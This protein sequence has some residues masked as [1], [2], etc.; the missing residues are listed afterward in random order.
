MTT[1]FTVEGKGVSGQSTEFANVVLRAGICTGGVAGSVYE[2]DPGQDSQPTLGHGPLAVAD[3]RAAALAPN[4]QRYA[5]K[6]AA[7]TAGE[8][9]T[10]TK[11]GSG[12]TLAVAGSAIDDITSPWIATDVK[13]KI[14]LG[15][16]L[17]TARVAVALDGAS[18]AYEFDLPAEAPATFIGT[19]DV[20]A[21]TLADL[22]TLTVILGAV[23]VTLTTPSSVANLVSQIHA[24]SGYA[25][26]LVQ[27]KYL[28]LR[29]DAAGAGEELT[30]GPGTANAL[31][32]FPDPV[33]ESAAEAAEITGTVDLTDSGLYGAM[34][35]LDGLTLIITSNLGASTVTFV[36]P[37]NAA[38][39]V[40]QITSAVAGKYVAAVVGDHLRLRST[41]VSATGT[42]LI[43]AGTSNSVLGFTGAAT[44]TGA[45]VVY[46][47]TATGSASAIT[48]PGTGQVITC[49]TG[50][51]V[52]DTIYSWTTTAP[53]CSLAA[54]LAAL[55]TAGQDVTLDFGL[56]LFVQT[57]L[58]EV[59][60]LAYAQALDTLHATWESQP[61]KR[62]AFW[63]LGSPLNTS[64]AALKD[65]FASHA[66]SRHGAV[67]HKDCYLGSSLPQPI[68][69]FRT[70]LVEQ[71]GLRNAQYSFSEDPGNGEFGALECSLRSPDKATLVR[72]EATEP[73][74]MGGSAGPGFTTL[75]SERGK[76]V[77]TRG[78]T[79]AGNTGPN[80][81]F[82]DEGVARA[83][84][85]ISAVIWIALSRFR[86][87]TFL[88]NANGTMQEKDAAAL[89][90]AFNTECRGKFVPTHFSSFTTRVVRSEDMSTT[91]GFTI[92]WSAQIRGQGEHV[93]GKLSV[94]GKV[95]VQ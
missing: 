91:R 81:R 10:V 73:I 17:G 72:N 40:S 5:C 16:P 53:R 37:A 55:T 19:E 52:R 65:S 30:I 92:Q 6:V 74:K 51:Y 42:L 38:A 41:T 8:I 48:L 77:F 64:D 31:L 87:K 35:D 23:T 28:R 84:K 75:Q 83:T 49:P 2:F 68:G 50:T 43:G 93:N 66:S 9:S 22:N 67:A 61:D 36:A 11:T 94:L 90:R 71:L 24:A 63:L 70:S 76:P 60:A 12:P 46:E 18:Y 3:A 13:A 21:L 59:D 25:C 27:G 79:R 45:N 62:F 69:S 88:L 7:T 26:D 56:D 15:G 58:D 57:P 1:T 89:D 44:D 14:L 85:A 86:N 80:A 4:A 47:V 39:I 32:G 20:T 29:T 82:V 34:G 54:M 33:V 95:E 78:V